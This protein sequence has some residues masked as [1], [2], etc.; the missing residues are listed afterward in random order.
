MSEAVGCWSQTLE[1]RSP[2]KQFSLKVNKKIMIVIKV[3]DEISSVIKNGRSSGG[4]LWFGEGNSKLVSTTTAL[5]R[6]E[7]I[8]SC[9]S[10]RLSS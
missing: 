10:R 8:L 5:Q 1:E 9:I 6:R 4:K 3:N 2:G 7:N